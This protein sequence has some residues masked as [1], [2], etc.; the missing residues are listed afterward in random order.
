[1]STTDS[2]V[3]LPARISRLEELAHN[4]WWSWRIDPSELFQSLDR[5]LWE[6]TYHNPV[7]MLQQISQAGLDAVAADPGFLR[8]YDGIIMALDRC[9]SAKDAWFTGK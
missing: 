6:L 5:T 4:L 8:R 7:K 3:I 9:L 1:M 2:G